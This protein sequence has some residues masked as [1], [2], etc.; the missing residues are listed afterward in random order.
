MYRVEGVDERG[1][2]KQRWRDQRKLESRFEV[3]NTYR[4]EGEGE[5]SGFDSR[6]QSESRISKFWE[7]FKKMGSE[8]VQNFKRH[9]PEL[10]ITSSQEQDK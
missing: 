10:I 6:T 1:F 9:H 4:S 8:I 7:R 2:V 3:H 5:G